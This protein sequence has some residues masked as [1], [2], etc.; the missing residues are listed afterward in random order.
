MTGWPL[1]VTSVV[2]GLVIGSFLNVVIYRL[3]RG[4]SLATPRSHC[5][6]CGATVAWYDNI[7]VVSYLILHGRCRGCGQRISIRYPVVEAGCALLFLMVALVFGFQWRTLLGWAFSA[8]LLA[9]AVID[10][11]HMIVPDR[12]VLP[13]AAIGFGAAVALDPGHWWHH[14]LAGLG[15]GLFLLV[16]ALIWSGGMGMGDV[17]LAVMLGAVLGTAVVVALFAAFLFGGLVGVLL[18]ALGV[19][20]RKDRIPFAPFLAVGGIVGFLAGDLIIN[21]YV[22]FMV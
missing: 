9:L 11:D 17:K 2:F 21:W 15:A 20:S 5:V 14:I 1:Y 13:A 6:S 19:R 10:M 3:P 18:I 12:I 7:P 4:E 22:S 16:V 8:T